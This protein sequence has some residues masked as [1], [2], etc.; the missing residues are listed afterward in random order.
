MLSFLKTLSYNGY[1]QHTHRVER[2]QT[3]RRAVYKNT[4]MATA[5]KSMKKTDLIK[6]V[7][8]MVGGTKVQATQIV[9]TLFET[10]TA[11]MAKGGTVDVAGFGKFVGKDRPA[12][13]AR[14]PK[15]GEAVKV[16]ATRVPKFRPSK[17]LK[18]RVVAGK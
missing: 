12:R 11:E 7:Q 6:L 4:S 3:F 10:I 1:T 2:M 18:E 14:N 17:P 5:V 8:D 13:T 15:T 9:E 16:P